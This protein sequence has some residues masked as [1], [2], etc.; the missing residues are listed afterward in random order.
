MV[1]DCGSG[2]SP[3]VAWAVTFLLIGLLM[4]VIWIIV[5]QNWTANDINVDY[6]IWIIMSFGLVF[7]LIGIIWLVVLMYSS[8]SRRKNCCEMHQKQQ[9]S[10]G[11][12][13]YNQNILNEP[14]MGMPS[15][16][17]QSGPNPMSSQSSQI[18]LGAGRN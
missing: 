18:L 13:M 16:F 12:G 4:F 10:E 7:M 11:F 8:S 6:W 14:A 15:Q 3:C 5:Y 17:P 9:Q 1:E 2:C